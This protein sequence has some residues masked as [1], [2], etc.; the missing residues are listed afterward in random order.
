ML[1]PP[2]KFTRTPDGRWLET[3]LPEDSEEYILYHSKREPVIYTRRLTQS[4]LKRI[5][6]MDG[7]RK[8]LTKAIR[9][10]EQ[11]EKEK[12]QKEF[13]TKLDEGAREGFD[14]LKSLD[15]KNPNGSGGVTL[16]RE[17]RIAIESR[18]EQKIQSL[19][20]TA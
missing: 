19:L 6:A 20:E 14:R 18:G 9:E 10:H 16:S 8:S 2:V 11:I 5:Y 17:D 12:R 15:R 4:V 13:R 7:N 3:L 1:V